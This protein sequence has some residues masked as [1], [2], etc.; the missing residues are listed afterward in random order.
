MVDQAVL[1]TLLAAADEAVQHQAEQQGT[2]EDPQRLDHARDET[3]YDLPPGIGADDAQAQ[4]GQVVR[5]RDTV[6]NQGIGGMRRMP[7][8]RPRI[9][10]LVFYRRHAAAQL[11]IGIVPDQRNRLAGGQPDQVPQRVR[12]I[13]VYADDHHRH[14]LAVLVQRQAHR[15]QPALQ[16]REVIAAA[17]HDAV[18]LERGQEAV[19]GVL[20]LQQIGQRLAGR[21]PGHQHQLAI[22]AG[23][24][25]PGQ[26]GVQVEHLLDQGTPPLRLVQRAYRQQAAAE[27]AQH[28]LLMAEL[29]PHHLCELVGGG[30]QLLARLVPRLAPRI[31]GEQQEPGDEHDQRGPVDLVYRPGLVRSSQECGGIGKG[32]HRPV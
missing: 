5:L 26:G 17:H 18:A 10:G 12:R 3:V 9:Q 16:Q 15:D 13:D 29:G 21:H 2:D 32:L 28:R 20:L 11:H 1:V 23:Q 25:E 27:Q 14:H 24:A 7:V 4:L 6:R 8:H 19:P 22:R 30:T 31:R